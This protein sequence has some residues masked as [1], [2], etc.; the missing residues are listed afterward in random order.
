MEFFREMRFSFTKANGSTIAKMLQGCSKVGALEEGKKIHG[1]E[2]LALIHQINNSGMCPK[3][4][5]W[6]ALISGS[7][8]NGNYRESLEFFSQMQQE[9]IRPNSV[10]ISSLL[11]NCGATALIDMYSK[12]GYLKGAYEV[13]KRI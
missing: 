4:V 6:T 13:F 7:S 11:R 9:G 2:A 8:Q 5:S 10:S 12:F 1:I 3:I